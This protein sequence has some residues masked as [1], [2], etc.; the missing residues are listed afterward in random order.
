MAT[1]IVAV[2]AELDRVQA[3]SAFKGPASPSS[4]D[5][6][7]P[8]N[9]ETPKGKEDE[10]KILM[11]CLAELYVPPQLSPYLRSLCFWWSRYTMNRQPGKA[12]PYFLRLRRPNVLDLIRENNLFTDVQDQVLLL[13]Q[14]DE[15]LRERRR[16]SAGDQM[17]AAAG[18]MDAAPVVAEAM[19]SAAGAV[20]SAAGAVVAPG[21]NADT[22]L[23]AERNKGVAVDEEGE[24]EAIKLLVDNIHSIPVRTLSYALYLRGLQ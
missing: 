15:E 23:G 11:E 7:S 22:G 18:G 17:S 8:P 14:F 19:A 4:R 10:K 12:L 9:G 5:A 6:A 21:T 2:S 1:V 16:K 24:S 3:S 13:V 20:A